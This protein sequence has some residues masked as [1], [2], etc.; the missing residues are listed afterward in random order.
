MSDIM[1]ALGYLSGAMGI[2][3]AV[4]FGFILGGWAGMQLG[5]RLF[6]AFNTN[7]IK[8]ENHYFHGPQKAEIPEPTA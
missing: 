6:G 1:H 3:F 8:T 2:A 5:T 4:G 7:V